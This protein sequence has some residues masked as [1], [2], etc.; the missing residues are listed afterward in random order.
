MS[1]HLTP[2]AVSGMEARPTDLGPPRDPWGRDEGVEEG[3][4]GSADGD[5]YAPDLRPGPGG[6]GG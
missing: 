3:V 1:T 5:R 6:V 2:G 4:R